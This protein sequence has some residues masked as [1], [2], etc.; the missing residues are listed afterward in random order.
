MRKGLT[1]LVVLVALAF[2]GTTAA[3]YAP[4]RGGAT[5]DAP[6]HV[7]NTGWSCFNG[8]SPNQIVW[9][10]YPTDGYWCSPNTATWHLFHVHP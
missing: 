8:G 7:T 10:R 9:I 6:Q 4:P 1:L 2:A 5:I 3:Q